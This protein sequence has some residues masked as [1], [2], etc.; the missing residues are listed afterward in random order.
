[1]ENATHFECVALKPLGLISS[2]LPLT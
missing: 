2:L 1:M